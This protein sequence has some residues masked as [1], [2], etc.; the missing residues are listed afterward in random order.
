MGVM[1]LLC[2]PLLRW[3]FEGADVQPDEAVLA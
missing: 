3:E 1:A 2:V